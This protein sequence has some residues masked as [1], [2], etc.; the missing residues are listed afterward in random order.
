MADLPELDAPSP[1]HDRDEVVTMLADLIMARE[2][3][4]FGR[5]SIRANKSSPYT[6][7]VGAMCSG[8]DTFAIGRALAATIEDAFGEQIEVLVGAPGLGA[9]LASQGAF[10]YSHV[11]N[12]N[13]CWAFA[14]YSQKGEL[15]FAGAA[16]REGARVAIVEDLLIS[17]DT[18]REMIRRLKELGCDVVGACSLI[19]RRERTKSNRIAAND[20]ERDTGVRVVCCA[21]VA[22]LVKK[23]P[24]SFLPDD[25]REQITK[26]VTIEGGLLPPRFTP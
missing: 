24:A 8:R 21:T 15:S 22:D 11:S 14:Q 9:V 1:S 23:M 7:D 10:Y 13:A 2:A 26:H 3:L 25:R 6:I 20:I 12:Y 19:D 18:T 16:L 5:F 4:R 17:G